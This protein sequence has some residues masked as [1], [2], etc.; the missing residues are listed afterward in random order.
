[1]VDSWRY[2]GKKMLMLV[3][4][5]LFF[6]LLQAQEVL[7]PLQSTPIHPST[8]AIKQSN[9]QALTLPFFA[10]FSSNPSDSQFS[11]LNFQF[12]I[13]SGATVTD[14]AGLLPPT[15]GVVTLDALDASG[16]LYP[17]ASTSLFPADTLT[18]LPIRL[19]GFTPHDMLVF[20][21]YYLPGGGEGNLWERIGDAPDPGD[22]LILEFF[23]PA[24]STWVPM[25]SRGGI[26]VDS[27]VLAT[28]LHWQYVAVPIID[29]LFFDS[30]FAFRFRNY[31]S[32]PVTAKPGLAGNCDYWHL[33]YLV[34][35]TNRS[36]TE[37]PEF[38]DVA[39]AAPAPTAL[40]AYRAMPA[41]QYRTADVVT[42][43]SLKI[44]NLYG[45]ELATQYFY[46]VVDD[47]GDTLYCYDGG[48]ENAP[49]FLPGEV[50]QQSQAHANP[51]MGYIFPESEQPASYTLIHIVREGV[52]G[53]DHGCNDTVRFLQV[54]D[55]YYAY[56]DGTAEN[57]YGLTSSS[58]RLYLASRFD[59]NTQDTLT[60]V[61]L[62]F[63]R[64][65]D[66][67]NEQIPFYI[68][69]WL[70]DDDGRPGT[71]LY[72]DESSR[73]PQHDGLN[74]FQRYR[75]ERPL[76]VEPGSLFVGFEQG[77]NHYINLGFDRS[78]N[79][80]DRIYYLTGTAWQQSILSGSLMMRPLFGAA[81]TVGI[82]SVVVGSSINIF[83][84]PATDLVTVEGLP[85]GSRIELYDASGRLCFSTF[86]FQLSTLNYPNG[87]YL[88]RTIT[89]EGTIHTVKIIIRH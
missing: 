81:A 4:V 87:L 65:S 24:D 42:D 43:F 70:A 11:I 9:N 75:L 17:D 46:A 84:N 77:N 61:D 51:P 72:R 69:I 45:S 38:R 15:V 66:G 14:G 78:F 60:A 49:P 54:F 79:S 59:L 76:V 13:P 58:S 47:A 25:W 28:G 82:E 10:D 36:T 80:A 2:N 52:G 12:S 30:L 7:L 32:L 21:F 27:L 53:D 3:G 48:Y 20:S 40:A 83:P 1:M 44:T 34:L 39:F 57:G 67:D 41:R 89:P 37:T 86:N 50:Y 8:Q 71:I 18:S 19:D 74:R 22:S 6:N 62:Y 35:D 31:C 16:D 73:H 63:N 56:D 64:T 33:D 23:R 85:A 68:T 5:S 26:E 55:N 29:S 88:L